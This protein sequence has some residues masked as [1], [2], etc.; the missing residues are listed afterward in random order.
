[1]ITQTRACLGFGPAWATPPIICRSVPHER[2]LPN[3]PPRGLLSLSWSGGT[4]IDRP[5]QPG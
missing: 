2:T 3:P 1:M 4:V 5:L